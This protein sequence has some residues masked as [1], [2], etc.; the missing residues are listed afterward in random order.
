MEGKR[1]WQNTSETF[2]EKNCELGVVYPEKIVFGNEGGNQDALQGR[3][4]NRICHQQTTP[5]KNG[6]R[7]SKRKKIVKEGNSG[8]QEERITRVKIWIN[9]TG[10]SS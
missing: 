2:Q 5:Q 8:R 1:K 10:S 6:K 4:I 7:D 3:R 9:T